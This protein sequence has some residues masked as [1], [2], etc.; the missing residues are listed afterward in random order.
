[1]FVDPKF[2]SDVVDTSVIGGDERKYRVSDSGIAE[3]C[4]IFCERLGR[5]HIHLELCG[6]E[7][8]ECVEEEGML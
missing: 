6:Y 3:M 2:Y 1:M 7:G 8:K 4:N 5:G